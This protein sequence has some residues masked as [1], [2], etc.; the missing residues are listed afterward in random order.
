[1]GRTMRE[2]MIIRVANEPWQVMIG[3]D[4]AGAALAM[5]NLES[6]FLAR[7]FGVRRD[8]FPRFVFAVAFA[9]LLFDLFYD[10][11][12]GSVEVAFVVFGKE[13][14]SADAETY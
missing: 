11:V 1:M 8:L 6:R 4:R 2:R 3:V 5:D 9:D 10:D 14:R 13:V 12:D 7:S